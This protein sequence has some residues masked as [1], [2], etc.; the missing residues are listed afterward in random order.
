MLLERFEDKGLAHYSY[1]L[2]CESAGI[3]AIV[4][5]R[6]D[7]DVY[8]EFAH[9]RGLASRTYL[10]RT[11]MRTSRLA[12]GNWPNARAR[13]CGCRRTMLASSTKS[14]SPTARCTT[15]RRSRSATC[16]SRRG[17]PRATRLSTS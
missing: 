8:R 15:R 9:Q 12:P 11:S 7:V 13:N 17:T 3:V 2:G 6:R 1:A 5:P 10:K 16:E 14:R 4:D